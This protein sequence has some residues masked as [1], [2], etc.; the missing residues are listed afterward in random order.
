MKMN[1][2]PTKLVYSPRELEGVLGLGRTAIYALLRNGGRL[3]SI[4]VGRRI[5]C[6][7]SELERFLAGARDQKDSGEASVVS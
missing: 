2:A 1:D 5:L 7:L 6:P 4:R 3:R